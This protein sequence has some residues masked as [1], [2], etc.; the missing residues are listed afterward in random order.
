MAIQDWI[1]VNFNKNF[2]YAELARLHGMSRRTLERRFKAATGD[3]PLTYHQR[4]RVEKAKRMLEKGNR[5]FEDL[6]FAR[7]GGFHRQGV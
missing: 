2:S 3:S 6:D 7:V 1:E 5:S 4:V